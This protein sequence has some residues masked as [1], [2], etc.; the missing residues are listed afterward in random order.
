VPHLCSANHVAAQWNTDVSHRDRAGK[1]SGRQ[2]CLVSMTSSTQ[3]SADCLRLGCARL[4][5]FVAVE[6]IME[7]SQLP[8]EV[9]LA[10]KHMT[11]MLYNRWHPNIL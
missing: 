8:A 10:L 5:E 11:T 1:T 2:A 6:R 4:Q 9:T 7:Y 3:I